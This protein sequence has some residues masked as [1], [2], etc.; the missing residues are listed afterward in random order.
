VL[1]A[2]A[3]VA[4]FIN[5]PGVGQVPA[6]SS[7]PTPAA[8]IA[9]QPPIAT[10]A[11]VGAA[12]TAP[13]PT[14]PGT[15]PTAP[16]PEGAGLQVGQAAL[17]RATRL[18]TLWTDPAGGVRVNERPRL[19]GGAQVTILAIE[20]QAVQVRTAEGVEGWIHEPADTALTT[21]LTRIGIQRRFNLGAA[22]RVLW[23]RGIPIRDAPRS[24]ANKLLDQ[25]QAGQGGAVREVLG[26]W[27]KLEFED[28]STGWARWYYDG[29]I[30]VDLAD[31]KPPPVF[32][33][34][35]LVQ[36]PR[37]TGDDVR[38][39]QRRLNDLAY[40]PDAADGIYGPDTEDAIKSFQTSNGLDMD[41]I[42]GPQTWE[43]LFS[44]DAVP[45]EDE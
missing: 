12:P 6:A 42:V 3:A 43:R 28:G 8:P 36:S 27:L 2:V 30:Y 18:R 25:L 16:P 7:V 11:L 14:A 15:S 23:S 4:L 19:L 29:E 44:P 5:R 37:L 17:T 45:Y 32:T 35:L 9:T 10:A 41:G 38:A 21:D 26:D 1:L 39:I 22:V 24:T 13:A 40:L 31:A 20:S 34:R 33:R